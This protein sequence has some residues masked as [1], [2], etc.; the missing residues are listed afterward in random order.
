[1][2][3]FQKKDFN[4]KKNVVKK[5]KNFFMNLKKLYNKKISKNRVKFAIKEVVFIMII[6]FLF[7]LIIG[8][9]IMYGRGSFRGGMNESLDEFID[10]YQDILNTYYEEVDS[11]ELLQSGIK[12]MIEYLG[13]PYST[14][15]DAEV[16]ND[17]NEE[18]EGEYS[19][20]GAEII[21]DNE[22]GV[23]SFGRI[24]DNTPA[25]KVGIKTGDVLIAVDGNS[26]ENLSNSEIAN[27]V[28]GKIGTTVLIKYKRDNLEKEVEIKRARV[29]I[30]SVSTKIYEKNGKKI[31]YMKISV[32]AANTS[33]QFKSKL[34]ELEKEG[35][36]SLLIDVRNNSGG[37]LTTV[38]D[39]IS[40]FTKKDSII[41]Q[42]STKGKI[43][44]VKDN[45]K[46]KREYPVYVLTNNNSASASEVLAAAIK[47]NYN[48][49][50]IGTKT[51]GKGKVQKA[52]NLSTGAK[53]KYTF[54][55]WLTPNGNS[56]DIKGIT[57]D[58]IIE[59][60]IDASQN[61]NQL[62]KVINEITK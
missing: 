11:N 42:L 52:Y 16:A 31:G 8:G 46:D 14:Y 12:G 61:D 54:Q 17:F 43:E 21:Y 27:K 57:P 3:L 35:F 62:E 23:V 2:N 59:N 29:D 19:G 60:V 13:D 20:I 5:M 50:V 9:V 49:L 30:E 38:T 15:M 28:K 51:Y 24:F 32:F 26:I 44:K 33:Q 45:T 18:V 4:N 25:S 53:V 40:I 34:N 48:G 58:I 6:A 37:Y 1:M 22:S 39:I 7:G 41:Y 47:E 56:I 10:T 55:E 36:D